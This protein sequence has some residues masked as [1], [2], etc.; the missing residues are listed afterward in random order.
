MELFQIGG[1]LPD[2]NYVFLGDYVDRGYHSL[3]VITLLLALK[4]KYPERL[5]LIRG[6]H[7][8]RAASST[9]GFY[10]EC[11]H[12]Y[13]NN[14]VWTLLNDVFDYMPLNALVEGKIY[15]THGGL[16]PDIDTLDQVKAIERIQETPH[17]GPMC[18]L[19]WSDPSEGKGWK[20]SPRCAGYLFGQE[21]SDKFNQANDLDVIAR[22]HQMVMAGYMYTHEG[23]V[24]TVF[25]APNYTYRAGNQAAMMQ[26]Y[27]NMERSFLQF[28]A[29]PD[30]KSGSPTTEV[31]AYFL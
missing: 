21:K 20:P 9:Y 24:V 17:E 7:E 6:N 12:K 27:E 26:L 4:V 1:E 23:N 2:T 25:S 11:M 22:G 30:Q 29:C 15:C 19:L 31:P 13:R 10:D 28:D 16:S 3:E 18:D 5:T 14:K 8:S